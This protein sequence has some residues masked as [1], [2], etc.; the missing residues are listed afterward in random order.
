MFKWEDIQDELIFFKVKMLKQV[1][2]NQKYII[3][4]GETMGE[5][6]ILFN[7]RKRRSLVR[8]AKSIV[9]CRLRKRHVEHVAEGRIHETDNCLINFYSITNYKCLLL[10]FDKSAGFEA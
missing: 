5:R 2:Y 4:V 10:F 3:D 7:Q 9:C 8:S 1:S 6:I